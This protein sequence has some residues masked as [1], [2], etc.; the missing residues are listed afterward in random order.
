MSINVSI[1]FQINEKLS[2]ASLTKVIDA[3]IK[4][5]CSY[6]T[7]DKGQ[8]VAGLITKIPIEKQKEHVEQII[9]G[10][11]TGKLLSTAISKIVSLNGGSIG[12]DYKFG[13]SVEKIGPSIIPDDTKEQMT[14]FLDFRQHLFYGSKGPETSNEIINLCKNFHKNH[15]FFE[16]IG[17]AECYSSIPLNSINWI[18]IINKKHADQLGREKILSSPVFIVE[19]LENGDILLVISENLWGMD[20]TLADEI[21]ESLDLKTLSEVA[22]PNE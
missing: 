16:M 22:P 13:D 14:L 20:N 17:G 21:S 7:V 4:S 10:D 11:P 19:E 6:N 9:E 2:V 12:L 18:N 1:R 5:G 3:L 8:W 15:G